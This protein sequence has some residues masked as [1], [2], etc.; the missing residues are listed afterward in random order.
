MQEIY[1]E[2]AFEVKGGRNGSLL[3]CRLSCFSGIMI[4]GMVSIPSE[5]N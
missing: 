3:F 4:L 2:P 1:G 5:G